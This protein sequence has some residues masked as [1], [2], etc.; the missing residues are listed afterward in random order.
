MEGYLIIE[1]CRID[2]QKCDTYVLLSYNHTE[3]ILRKYLKI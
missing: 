1:Q 3:R 2:S